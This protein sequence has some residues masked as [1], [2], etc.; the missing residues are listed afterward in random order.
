MIRCAPRV[1][2][3]VLGHLDLAGRALCVD[4]QQALKGARTSSGHRSPQEALTALVTDLALAFMLVLAIG[5][6]TNSYLR[7]INANPNRRLRPDVANDAIC[8]LVKY[9]DGVERT[10]IKWLEA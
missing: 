10:P 4:L 2:E 7:I 9:I 6:L 1:R 5:L 3:R 8:V